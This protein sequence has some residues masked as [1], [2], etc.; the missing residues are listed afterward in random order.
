MINGTKSWIGNAHAAE[1]IWL[2]VRTDVEAKL[3]LA[4]ISMFMV[5]MAAAGIR[6]EPHRALSG[7][8]CCT[9]TFDHVRVTA[10]PAG[11]DR[12]ARLSGMAVQVQ[13]VNL[14]LAEAAEK[15]ESGAAHTA[16]LTSSMAGVLAAEVAELLSRDALEILGPTVALAGPDVPGAG[17]FE[18][19]LRLSVLAFLGGGTNDVQRGLIARGL[20]LS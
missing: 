1:Y 3:P 18:Q 14:L 12:R 16:R 17:I 6:T 15:T 20:G 13:A 8:I 7:Q 9:V 4:G 10:G 19:G 2:A 5:P 11:S